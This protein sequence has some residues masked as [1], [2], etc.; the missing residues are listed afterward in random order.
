M[1][2]FFQKRSG[3]RKDEEKLPAP[4]ERVKQLADNFLNNNTIEIINHGAHIRISPMK[5]LYPG[6]GEYRDHAI[7]PSQLEKIATEIINEE[8]FVN[9]FLQNKRDLD[10]LYGYF[11]ARVEGNYVQM[12]DHGEKLFAAVNEIEIDDYDIA[13]LIKQSRRL[14]PKI[15]TQTLAIDLKHV[16]VFGEVFNKLKSKLSLNFAN[17]PV[18]QMDI[19]S[20][21]IPTYTASSIKIE[22]SIDSY[23]TFKLAEFLEK[24]SQDINVVSQKD[25][26]AVLAGALTRIEKVRDILFGCE[27]SKRFHR[28]LENLEKIIDQVAEIK[29]AYSDF[30]NK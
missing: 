21:D 7:V 28:A 19:I 1:I 22:N 17:L 2:K 30:S 11:V 6:Y 26:Q 20:I 3:D 5:W 23:F 8:M 10:G 24:I 25:G 12:A 9:N 4:E 15:D 18:T 14:F 16:E 27:Q 13:V 29:Q